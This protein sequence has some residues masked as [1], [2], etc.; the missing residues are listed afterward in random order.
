MLSWPYTAA[1]TSLQ[2]QG[3]GF[4][5]DHPTN[6]YCSRVPDVRTLRPS[7]FDLNC[8]RNDGSTQNVMHIYAARCPS[9]MNTYR[10]LLDRRPCTRMLIK[11]RYRA[12]TG[13]RWPR[14]RDD[15]E[16]EKGPQRCL[17]QARLD[18]EGLSLLLPTYHAA[19]R[20]YKENSRSNLCNLA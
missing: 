12:S 20:T 18:P 13:N 3:L 11:D 1:P 15:S 10:V 14:A 8:G 4:I 2:S 7:Q 17:Q 9:M 6:I 5:Y 16:S 19:A